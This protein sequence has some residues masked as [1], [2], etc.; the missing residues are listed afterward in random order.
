M[1]QKPEFNS[2]KTLLKSILISKSI[3]SS[4]KETILFP[5]LDRIINLVIEVDNDISISDIDTLLTCNNNLVD[6][7]IC[8][9]MDDI[10]IKNID[11][12]SYKKLILSEAEIEKGS[13]FNKF[14]NEFIDK[15]VQNYN[16]LA[17]KNIQLRKIRINDL[18]NELIKQLKNNVINDIIHNIYIRTQLFEKYTN[19]TK[20]RTIPILR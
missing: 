1:L 14:E 10:S 12:E 20:K 15:I 19:N 6:N 7:K 5:V 17:E 9:E 8:T 18:D 13:R 3:T 2:M 4:S 16:D 11:K